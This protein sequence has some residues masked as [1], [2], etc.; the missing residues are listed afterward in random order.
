MFIYIYST[1]DREDED[2]KDFEETHCHWVGCDKGDFGSQEQ[3]VRVRKIYKYIPIPI[4]QKINPSLYVIYLFN[5][6]VEDEYL[7][8][9]IIFELMEFSLLFSHNNIAL[10]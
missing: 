10:E 8:C 2:E 3:L 7:S 5:T 9:S 6:Q 4:K 1:I